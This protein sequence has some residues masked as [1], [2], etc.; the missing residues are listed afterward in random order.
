MPHRKM[1]SILFSAVAAFQIISAQDWAQWRGPNRDGVAKDFAAPVQWPEKLKMIWKTEVGSGYSSPVVS[2]DRAWIHTR[3]GEEEVVSCLDLKT[4]KTLWSKSYTVAFTK[5][6]Y[7]T[8]MGKGPHSTPV[9]YDG[10]LYTLGVTAILSCFDA[11]TGELKWRREF[12]APD[13]SKMFCGTA[14]SPIVDQGNLIVYVGDDIKGGSM[15]AL[16]PA[17][18]K[19]RW[20]WAGDGPGYASPIVVE[21]E[22]A[23]QIVTMTDKSVIGVESKTGK[24]LWRMPWPDEWNE[25]IVTPIPYK[26]LLI[27]SGVRKGT[28]AVQLARNGA[29]WTSKQVWHNPEIAMYMNS[30]VLEGEHLYG[31]SSKRKGQ[32]FCLEAATGKILWITE[33]REGASAAILNAKD[34]LLILTSDANLIVA[35]KSVKGFEQ[36]AKYSVADSPTYAH[37]APTGKMI[38]VKDDAA[39]TLWGL[40]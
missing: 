9:L 20:K 4:G 7:A 11:A 39:M 16:D 38:L 28:V 13:T 18:G 37:P 36:V 23:R 22:G 34:A 5:N 3:R 35:K 30:P 29:E 19:E 40:E 27:F 12:G 14:F 24:L 1:L 2:K 32:Y 33:G 31:M 17:T 26:N 8:Q 21:H 10:R 6:Q 25:N 15:F